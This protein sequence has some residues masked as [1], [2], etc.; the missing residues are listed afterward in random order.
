MVYIKTKIKL[1]TFFCLAKNAKA[2]SMSMP[3]GDINKVQKR[4][5]LRSLEIFKKVQLHFDVNHLSCR[6]ILPGLGDDEVILH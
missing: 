5:I 6:N 4:K 1:F 2:E 3:F